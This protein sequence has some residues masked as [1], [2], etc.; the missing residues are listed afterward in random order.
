MAV[1]DVIAPQRA[2]A[3]AGQSGSSCPPP[4]AKRGF[5]RSGFCDVADQ[6]F[7]PPIILLPPPLAVPSNRCASLKVDALDTEALER[8]HASPLPKI[9]RVWSSLRGV[10]LIWK[11]LSTY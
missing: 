4:V 3:A 7:E 11:R 10:L 8:V 2:L 9:W 1:A 5:V 6:R